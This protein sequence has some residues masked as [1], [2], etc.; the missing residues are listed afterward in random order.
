MCKYYD[1]QKKL[2]SI[3]YERPV[4]CNVDA[5]YES[6]LKEVVD[7]ETYYKTN[8]AECEKLKSEANI[9]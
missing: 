9:Q 6:Q 2:C 5:Y 4:I 8:Y 1:E 3:Y 7:R